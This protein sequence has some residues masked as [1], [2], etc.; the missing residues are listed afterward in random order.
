MELTTS[1][2]IFNKDIIKPGMLIQYRA[3]STDFSYTN[4][5][6]EKVTEE[7][8]YI[9][10]VEKVLGEYKVKHDTI[11]IIESSAN[12]IKIIGNNKTFIQIEDFYGNTLMDFAINSH[13]EIVSSAECKIAEIEDDAPRN[14]KII[15][16]QSTRENIL[17][18][19]KFNSGS[20]EDKPK[21][22]KTT[23]YPKTF[24]DMHKSSDD[25]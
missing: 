8:I 14:R 2:K 16:I 11:D 23:P 13:M 22:V 15:R 21:A 9:I 4:A 24:R 6:I 19:S 10:R 3:N 17:T 12:T 5:I 7:T 20:A 1:K 25:E 18:D